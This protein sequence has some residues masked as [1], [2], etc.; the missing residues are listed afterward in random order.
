MTTIRHLYTTISGRRL[1]YQEAGALNSP[2]VVLLHGF[3][4][5]SFMFR[6]LIP[7]LADLYRVIAPDHLGFGLSDA[8]SVDEFDYTFD[9]LASLTAGLLAHLG[10]VR[11]ALYVH[12]YGAP[13]AWRLALT[14][15]RSILAIV[16]QNGNGYEAGFEQAFWKPLREYWYNQNPRTETAVRQA[17]TLDAIR[18]QYLHGVPDPSLV[19][20]E[21]WYHDHA[22]ISRPGNDLVQL[23]LFADYASN[24][25]VY[26][27][28]H[29]YLRES[30]VP[31]MALWGRNAEVFGPAGA[32]AFTDDLPDAEIHLL[33][34]GHF[35]LESHLDTVVGY[36][37]GFL[38]RTLP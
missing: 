33:D 20:P 28:L 22:L 19:S 31:L 14:N 1:F 12:D 26:P 17:L 6:N 2:P 30:G 5:S 29:A 18:R 13:V 24:L 15:P 4:A 10:V 23:R 8:P 27:R 38:G 37:R 9:A 32:L 25:A 36:T 34:G 11:Y 16:T 21:T 7:E 3:P 35:L